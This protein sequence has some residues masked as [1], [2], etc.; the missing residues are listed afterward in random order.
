MTRIN[1][2]SVNFVDNPCSFKQPFKLEVTFEA[3][4]H[5]E[6]DIEWQLIYVGSGASSEHDQLLDS[7]FIWPTPEGRHQFVFQEFICLGWNVQ[8]Q[9][10]EPEFNENPPT[11]TDESKL[12]RQVMVDGIDGEDI[13]IDLGAEEIEDGDGDGNAIDEQQISDDVVASSSE[14]AKSDDPEVLEQIERERIIEMYEKGPEDPWIDDWENLDW[15]VYRKTD[16]HGFIHKEGLSEAERVQSEKERIE[17]E[18]RREKKWLS[19]LSQCETAGEKLRI[20]VWPKLLGIEELKAQSKGDDIYVKLVDR[21]RL[22]SKDIKQIDLD[23]NRTYRDN[24]MFRRRYGK[25]LC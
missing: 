12:V 20:R 3:F 11:K 1:I 19:M 2:V 17:T 22:I 15:D 21:A 10:N 16:R 4:S 8:V 13:A 7:V 9:Y 18:I 24:Q 25:G 14:E 5:L 6:K 23:I